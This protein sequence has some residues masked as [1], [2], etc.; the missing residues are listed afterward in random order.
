MTDFAPLDTFR[1]AA[2]L[3][4]AERTTRVREEF[5]ARIATMAVDDEGR[6]PF[7]PPGTPP[8][9]HDRSRRPVLALAAIAALL[10][11]A[12]TGAFLGRP[13]GRASTGLEE[14]AVRADAQADQ[15]LGTSDFLYLVDATTDRGSSTTREQWTAPDGT[16][17]ARV[18]SLPLTPKGRDPTALSLYPTPGSLD[19]AGMTYQELRDLP[20]EPEPLLDRLRQLGVASSSRP[21]AQAEAVAGVAALDVTPPAVV[22]AAIRALEQLGGRDIGPVPDPHG[23]VGVGIRGDNGDGTTWLVVIDAGSGAALAVHDRMDPGAPVGSTPGR[24]WTK[25]SI[26]TSLPTE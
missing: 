13:G 26:T 16:G 1:D 15:P 9:A 8:P 25:Q 5:R 19:F 4:D 2:G 6:R 20:T 3:P 12:G 7:D 22:A 17:Q 23:R 18:A 14:L 21:G 24:V 11:I 10:L